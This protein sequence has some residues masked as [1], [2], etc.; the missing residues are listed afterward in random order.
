MGQTMKVVSLMINLIK[1]TENDKRILIIVF[2]AFIIIFLFIGLIV[3]LIKRIMSHQGKQVDTYMYNVVKAKLVTKPHEFRKVALLK[4]H[5]IFYKKIRIPFLLLLIGVVILLQ[6]MIIAK[7][8]DLSFY[9]S[10][11]NGLNSLF[12]HWKWE[13]VEKTK[14]FGLQTF[15]PADWPELGWSPKIIWSHAAITAYLS[16]PCFLVGLILYLGHLVA[17]ISRSLR[18]RQLSKT[19]FQKSLSN[20]NSL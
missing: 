1:L 7:T 20:P 9:F 10:R 14:I 5:Q 16:F 4:N 15:I 18:A 3:S 8:T 12:F 6:Y 19:F 17:F 13:E 11:E 2:L